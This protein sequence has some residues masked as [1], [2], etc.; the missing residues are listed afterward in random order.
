VQNSI[1]GFT[2]NPQRYLGVTATDEIMLNHYTTN[3]ISFMR[4]T[5]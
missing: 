5:P 3:I 4:K 2:G 1:K